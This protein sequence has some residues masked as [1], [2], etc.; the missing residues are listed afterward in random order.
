MSDE[1]GFLRAL[2]DAPDDPEPRLIFADWL[3]D[4]GDPRGEFLRAQAELAAW[5]PDLKRRTALQKTERDWLARHG[6]SRLLGPLADLC[7]DWRYENALARVAIEARRFV[8]KRFASRGAE[9]LRNAWVRTLRLERLTGR[10]FEVAA[11]EP[12]RAVA[13]LDLSGLGLTDEDVTVLLASPH[14]TELRELDLS[15]NCLTDAFLEMFAR[16]PLAER[17]TLLDVRNNHQLVI[18][19]APHRGRREP[20]SARRMTAAVGM[21]LAL[22]PAGTFLMGSPETEPQRYAD[23]GPRH[24]VTLTRPFYLGVYPVTQQQFFQVLGRNPS[25]FTP[26]RRGG[27]N[28]PVEQV[29][30]DDA[31]AFCRRLS[32]LPG[33]KEAGRV[34]RLP[35]EAEWEHACRAGSTTPFWWGD[36]ITSDRANFDGTDPYHASP[37]SRFLQRTTVVGAYRPNPF[38]L[39][40]VHGNVWEWVNDWM[41][42]DYY[43][44]SPAVDPRGPKSGHGYVVRG[45]SWF[46]SGRGCRS[47]HRGQGGR[48]GDN[49]IGF[50]VACPAG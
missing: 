10:V 37:R 8:T 36:T 16:S 15:H 13:G 32:E 4:H 6:P 5:V 33:E 34:Y 50:R 11:A 44:R 17:L 49:Q 20:A 38:G 29:S 39:Y 47:A 43:R 42:A 21:E 45:G 24:P 19:L 27:H 12:L 28:H 18:P 9:M 26:Q 3:T 41:G 35:T 31:V 46:S 7:V 25:H 2:L 40:D 14:L 1:A 30:W 22:I 48:T 23:E